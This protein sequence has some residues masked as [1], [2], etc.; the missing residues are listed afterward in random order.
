[1]EYKDFYGYTISEYGDVY[2]KFGHKMASHDNGRGY[3]VVWLT[4]PQGRKIFGIHRLVALCFINNPEN[5]PEVNHIVPDKLNNHYKNLEWVDRG[6]NIEHAYEHEL[7]SAKGEN[8]SRCLTDEETVREICQLLEE[9]LT[10]S[11]IRDMGYKYSLVRSIKARRNW[12]H[13]SEDYSF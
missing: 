8:N 1:M 10:P 2:N 3:L 12:K 11:K 5:L 13:I 6:R 4:L 9:K 7:R